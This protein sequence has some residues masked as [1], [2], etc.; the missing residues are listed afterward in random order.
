MHFSNIL[1]KISIFWKIW[2]LHILV[3][4]FLLSI[5]II[6]QDFNV[7]GVTHRMTETKIISRLLG[8]SLIG[9]F[10][11]LDGIGFFIMITIIF[12]YIIQ[13]KIKNIFKSYILSLIITYP[14]I[15]LFI[16][17]GS[18]YG[19]NSKT[20]ICLI[21]TILINWLVFKKSYQKQNSNN[22]K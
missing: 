15:I 9:L 7:N 2:I 21:I 6:V 12:N 13:K 8:S 4:F 19:S 20:I 22:V 17:E 14:I 1:P 5:L 18:G 10:G 16:K 11:F 3:Y